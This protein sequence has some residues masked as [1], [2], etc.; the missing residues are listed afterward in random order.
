MYLVIAHATKTYDGYSSLYHFPRF[1]VEADDDDNAEWIA[2]MLL[3]P[4]GKLTMSDYQ[5]SISKV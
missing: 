5:Y 1:Y 2:R 4:H 3:E